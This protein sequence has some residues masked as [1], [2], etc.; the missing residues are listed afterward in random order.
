MKNI[1]SY[2]TFESANRI[3]LEHN[4]NKFKIEH[5]HTDKYRVIDPPSR[6]WDIVTAGNMEE[7][8]EN[9]KTLIDDIFVDGVRP[10]FYPRSGTKY[11]VKDDL[12]F[13]VGTHWQK[14]NGD[15][16]VYAKKGDIITF[17]AEGED[18]GF[19]YLDNDKNNR[20]KGSKLWP[21]LWGKKI[22]ELK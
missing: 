5:I 14:P 4:G 15:S 11:I 12:S 3:E 13:R 10:N 9:A 6:T 19:W 7:A 8:I 20:L 21:L 17:D 18:D 2:K 22:Q 1:K 16:T